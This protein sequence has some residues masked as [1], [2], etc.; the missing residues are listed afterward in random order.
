MPLSREIIDRTL[1]T[2]QGEAAY[3]VTET[4]IDAGY[5]CFWVGGAVRDMFV[6][7]SPADIDMAVSAK[8][9]EVMKLFPK[10]DSSAAELGSVVVSLKGQT[11]ELT[12][13]RSDHEISDGRRPES[14]RFGTRE[15]DA[16]RRDATINAMYW[17]PVSRELF[18]PCG[19]EADLKEK[20]VR[21]IGEPNVRIKEDALR[22]FRLVR[23]RA[24]IDGQYHPETYS[25]L[26]ENVA[27]AGKLSGTRILEELEK[28]LQ[29]KKPS[30]A[31]TDLL[32]LGVLQEILPELE[33][34]KGIA[35]PQQYHHE[36]DVWNHLLQC[37]DAF[38]D[39]HGFDVRI[40]AL[41][42]D[43]G[44]P[45]TF[46]LTDRIHFDK[47]AKVSA[48][49]AKSILHKLQMPSARSQKICWLI[50]HHMMMGAFKTLSDERKAHWYFHPWFRELLQVMSLDIA[51]TDPADF[52]L[53]DSIIKDYDEFLNAHPRPE[54]PLLKGEEVMQILGIGS[55][56]KVGKALQALHDAQMR[57]EVT[58]KAEAR[59]FL[60]RRS[61]S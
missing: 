60:T 51:G 2:K 8:P 1:A 12:T 33:A 22:I 26:K 50:E 40:A 18:D 49:T 16:L 34:C 3:A 57:K 7:Q 19:G 11:F 46:S 38:T 25:A 36:G 41:F 53:Y 17:N 59:A 54:K 20:L 39:D 27:L 14:V 15:E 30:K 13:F 55:G 58:T 47:H 32:E 43:I 6:G 37:I 21:F 29:L 28:I 42:H 48:E 56:E 35:Q 61:D 44:K 45:K 4:M 31:L 52:E 9:E 23:L 5:E 10:C 24:L